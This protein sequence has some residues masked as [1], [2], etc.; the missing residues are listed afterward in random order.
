MGTSGLPMLRTSE[1]GTFKRCRW[2]WYQEFHELIKPVTDVPPLRFGTLIHGA[3]ASYYKVGLRRGPHP[4]PTFERLFGENLVATA[5]QA[6]L[7]TLDLEEDPKWLE[8][9]ELGIRM[10]DNYVE[11]YG[12]DDEWKV[13]ATEYQFQTIIQKPNGT[14]WFWYVGTVDGVW[15][16]RSTGKIVIPDHKTT[17]AINTGY[18]SMDP[19]ATAYWTFGWDALINARLL[20]PGTQLDGLIFNFLRK[21]KPDERA[22][23]IEDGR[24][25][26]TNLDG[27]ISAKQPAPYFRRVPIY[28]DFKERERVRQTVLDEYAEIEAVHAGRLK[29]YKNPGQFTC[30]G[31]WLL[32]ICELHEIGADYMSMREVTTK[33]WDPYD[34]HEIKEA[35]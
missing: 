19:Q 10:L 28:R 30:P 25:Y 7:R 27:K 14:P 18:L 16:S 29:P 24:K 34:A 12:K 33:A 35:R 20:D 26:F 32:D 13:L 1:R 31:C 23:V 21:A 17:A 2:K 4:R 22:Y 15:Q 9:F 8:H 6:K 5:K 11:H 3:L